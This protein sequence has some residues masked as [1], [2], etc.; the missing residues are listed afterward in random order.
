MQLPLQWNTEICTTEMQSAGCKGYQICLE[1]LGICTFFPL[2]SLPPFIGRIPF[3]PNPHSLASSPLSFSLLKSRHWVKPL[4]DRFG[5]CFLAGNISSKLELFH[6]NN[7]FFL[8]KFCFSR[9]WGPIWTLL[10]RYRWRMFVC[11]IRI[12]VTDTTL[13]N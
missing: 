8:M 1:C 2:F 3:L 6:E 13:R 9:C 12:I 10:S 4:N 7:S 11:F 5:F